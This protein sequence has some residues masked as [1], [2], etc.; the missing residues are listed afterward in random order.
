M[1]YEP[2]GGNTR[3]PHEPRPWELE[4]VKGKYIDQVIRPTGLIDP[5]V[6]VR[7]AKNQVD[8]L[9]HECKKTIEKNYRVLITT[10]TKRT[11]TPHR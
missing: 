3:Q 2:R 4:Q 8:D 1:Q 11:K 7:P 9:M 10:L 5:P 6:E